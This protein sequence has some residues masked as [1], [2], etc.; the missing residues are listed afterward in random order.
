MTNQLLKFTFYFSLFFTLVLI[1]PSCTSEVKEEAVAEK[2]SGINIDSLQT[3]TATKVP[4]EMTIHGDTRTDNYYWLNQREDQE[5]LDY[6]NAENTYTTD[7]LKGTEAFQ[8]E[9][10][11]EMIGR[12]KKNDTSVPYKYKGYF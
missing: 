6:L 11:D 8:K 7:G 3:P 1:L 10:Y 2:V 5:V 4:K 9:L 12:I